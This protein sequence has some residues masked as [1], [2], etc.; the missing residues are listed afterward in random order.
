M[1]RAN[2]DAEYDY[3]VR[4]KI[5]AA[6]TTMVDALNGKPPSGLNPPFMHQP[7]ELHVPFQRDMTAS[8]FHGRRTIYPLAQSPEKAPNALGEFYDPNLIVFYRMDELSPFLKYSG[9]SMLN[10][11]IDDTISAA[12]SYLDRMGYSVFAHEYTHYLDYSRI[13]LKYVFIGNEYEESPKEYNARFQATLAVVEDDFEYLASIQDFQAIRNAL[14]DFDAFR[15]YIDNYSKFTTLIHHFGEGA[16]L[17]R[18]ALTR[19]H[20]EYQHLRNKIYASIF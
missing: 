12:L 18:N 3:K 4:K 11:D 9:R 10:C 7:G 20:G 15:K 14:K 19:L 8:F 16:P 2:P 17:E 1:F 6:Y 5:K 13:G